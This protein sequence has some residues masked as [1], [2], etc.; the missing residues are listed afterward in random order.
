MAKKLKPKRYNVNGVHFTQGEYERILAALALRQDA[1]KENGEHQRAAH[2][3]RI[4]GKIV[5][6][7]VPWEE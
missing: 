6:A 1:C 7:F 4:T 2:W 5:R 3:H